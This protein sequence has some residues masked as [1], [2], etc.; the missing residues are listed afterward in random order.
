MN[1]KHT[2]I[3]RVLLIEDEPGVVLTLTDRLLSQGYEVA[4]EADGEAG[5]KRASAEPFELIILDHAS[6][7]ERT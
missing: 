7:E 2:P 3:A 1:P 4:S 6:Q 5:L